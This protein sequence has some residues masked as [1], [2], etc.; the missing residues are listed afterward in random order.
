MAAAAELTGSVKVAIR[1]ESLRLYPKSGPLSLATGVDTEFRGID[2]PVQVRLTSGM[3]LNA[4]MDLHIPVT[5]GD[6]IQV[7]VNSTVTAFPP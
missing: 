2:K 5:V 7:G 4:V 3:T 1:P 6:Q